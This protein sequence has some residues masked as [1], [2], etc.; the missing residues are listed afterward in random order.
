VV[1]GLIITVVLL[2][3]WA[4]ASTILNVIVG[5]AFRELE[6]EHR[7]LEE[8][9]FEL[10]STINHPQ[11]ANQ[12]DIGLVRKLWDGLTEWVVEA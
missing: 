11:V 9:Y 3:L 10:V 4:L 8:K 7:D 6:D 12:S 2:S 5:M 1:L